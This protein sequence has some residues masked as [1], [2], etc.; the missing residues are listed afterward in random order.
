MKAFFEKHLNFSGRA[1]REKFNLYYFVGWIVF[2]ACSSRDGDEVAN[3][4]GPP[5]GPACSHRDFQ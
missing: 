3:E 2:A 5:P 4:F 1:D